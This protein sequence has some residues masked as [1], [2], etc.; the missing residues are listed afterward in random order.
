VIYASPC[1][2]FSEPI[3]PEMV[4]LVPEPVVSIKSIGGVSQVLHPGDCAIFIVMKSLG[5]GR[6]YVVDPILID[7]WEGYSVNVIDIV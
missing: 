3:A 4:W 5:L 2:G 7:S 6:I 1:V